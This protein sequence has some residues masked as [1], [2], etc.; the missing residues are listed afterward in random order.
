M[1]NGYGVVSNVKLRD[2]IFLD[3]NGNE[4]KAGIFTGD[5]LE[6]FPNMHGTGVQYNNYFL[7]LYGN[8]TISPVIYN[9]IGLFDGDKIE[10]GKIKISNGTRS[11]IIAG[12]LARHWEFINLAKNFDG[13]KMSDI[14]EK[15]ITN[16]TSPINVTTEITESTTDENKSTEKGDSKDSKYGF[17]SDEAVPDTTNENNSTTNQ[18]NTHSMNHNE[19]RSGN[20]GHDG[21][22]YLR[23]YISLVMSNPYSQRFMN[24]LGNELTCDLYVE[25]DD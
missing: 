10:N 25:E 18:T 16:A 15:I 13:E 19:K 24:I 2:V 6:N 20:D 4:D 7:S 12:I 11:A 9:S 8:R 23:N 1:N 17:D 3:S 21:S 22:E 5:I 14:S